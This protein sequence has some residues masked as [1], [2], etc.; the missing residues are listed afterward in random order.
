MKQQHVKNV[1]KTTLTASL[2]CTTASF[3]HAHGEGSGHGV[4]DLGTTTYVGRRAIQDNNNTT[5]SL[6]TIKA[7]KLPDIG[8]SSLID[9]LNYLPGVLTSGGGQQG[10]IK[11]IRIRGMRP[12]DT[13]VRVDGVRLS[14]RLSNLDLFVGNT[15]LAGTS[16]IE[17]LKGGQSSLY[18]ASA[19]GGVLNIS[20]KR[21][22]DDFKNRFRVEAGSFNSLALSL[23][24]AGTLDKEQK[25]KY[26][27][28]SSFSTTDNDTY[29]DNSETPGFDNDSLSYSSG[30]RLDY[31]LNQRADFGL[32][33]RKLDSSN[34]TPQSSTIDSEFIL[35][36]LFADVRIAE[37]WQS[38]LTLSYLTENTEFGGSFPSNTDYDQFGISWEN[39]LKYSDSGSVSFGAEYENNDLTAAGITNGRKDHY[40]AVYAHHAYQIDQLTIDTGVRYEDYQ[41]FGNHTSWQAGALYHLQQSGTKFRA[42]I[43]SGFNTPDF[44]DLYGFA[45]FTSGNANLDPETTL[46]WD[47]GVE[48]EIGNQLLSLSFFETDIEDI[49]ES[50]FNGTSVVTSNSPGKTKASGIEATIRGQLVDKVNYNLNYTWLDRSTAGQPAQTANATIV[51]DVNEKTKV[52]ISAQYL[53]QR[54][55]GGDPL[56][57][58]FE[59]SVF[60]NYQVNENVRIHARI[61]NITDTEYSHVDFTNNFGSN[62]PAR[63]LGVHAGVTVE[64]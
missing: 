29:G 17:L 19:N 33:F 43:A 28:F 62:S 8:T 49:I 36:T 15:G 16:K 1:L 22:S 35:G 11:G 3:S 14:R 12:E 7:S 46:G 61:N 6:L 63:R 48:Q 58:V 24:Y 59:M 39:N 41:S 53:D 20:S 38:K 52:G 56:D 9:S 27:L 40:S 26:S 25:L 55:Y 18:G 45:P 57:D 5:S 32:T 4:E 23:E 51:F 47:I 60:G 54:S 30:L 21:A 31:Q 50:Q 34:E 10:T 13:Q 42:N 64:W 44:L 2:V 37:N